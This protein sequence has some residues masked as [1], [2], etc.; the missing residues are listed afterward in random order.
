VVMKGGSAFGWGCHDL[1][2]VCIFPGV[3]YFVTPVH[4]LW[5]AS[6]CISSEMWPVVVRCRGVLFFEIVACLCFGEKRSG[7]PFPTFEMFRVAWYP[8]WLTALLT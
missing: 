4:R 8:S 1:S 3:E 6:N 7:T 2:Q 5:I